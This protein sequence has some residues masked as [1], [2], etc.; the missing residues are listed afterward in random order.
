MNTMDSQTLEDTGILVPQLDKIFRAQSVAIVGASPKPGAR[1]RI[2]KVLIKHGFEGRIYPVSPS[3]DEVEG[4]KA[5]KTLA[6]LPEVPDVAL[7][8]T[9]AATVPGLIE[10]CGEKGVTCA[11]VYSAGFEEI[12]SGKDIARQLKEAA[13]KHNVNVLGPNGQGVWSIKSKTMLTFG[14]AAFGLENL[15]HSPIAIVSQS[16]ALAGAIGN[17]LQRNGLGCSYIVSVGNETCMDA[18]DALSW[19]IEQDDV[20]VVALYLEGL[21]DAA[22]LL[23]LAARARERGVQ[24]VTLKAGRSAFGQEATASHTGKIASP[25]GIYKDVLD[26][27]GIIMVES[28]GE[29]MAAVEVLSFMPDPR[30][31]GDP[32]GG[33][34]VMSSSGGA[35]ALLADHSDERGLPMATFSD[36]AAAKLEDILPEFAR[37]ANPVDLTGQIRSFPNLFRDTLAVLNE[38]P[39]TEAIVVQFASSGLRDLLD[40]GDDFKNAAKESGLPIVIT[41]AQEKID[42]AIKEDFM[43]AGILISDDPANT[44]R[45]LKWLYDRKRFKTIEIAKRDTT[46]SELTPPE[47][48][49]EMMDFLETASVTPANWRVIGPDESAAEACKD[50]TYPLVVKVLP[51]AA[52][53][54][55]ELG[56]VKLKVQTPED[57]DAHAAEFRKILNKPDMGVLVQEMVSDSV[58]VVLSCL[59]NTDF[60][61]VLSIGSGGVA[62]ELYRDV[63]YLALPVTPAQVEAALKKLKL[64]HLLEGFRGAPKAD[65]DALI[66]AA[67]GFGDTI[68][69]TPTLAEAEVNPV[70]VRPEGKG[71]V[72]VDFLG[73]TRD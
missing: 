23:P 57:V 50:L 18:L 59:G 38:D 48:W 52:E 33:I 46:Q 3:A 4:H 45:A 6:D 41:F 29:A 7:I 31:S 21:D 36:A 73:T 28:L 68:L 22:R 67:V 19:V 15:R 55:T 70:M 40:N 64:W 14:A 66:K 37:K 16:G 49:G 25:Y 56:L 34:S 51:D 71:L 26:Q 63:T 35:G 17:Y 58:E 13:R 8:I 32:M 39:R 44:M 5:Y 27:A 1:N 30:V 61:P 53:H 47:T 10:E 54:K 69:R 20:R 62:I 43:A 9:P 72:A 42:L 2:V 24:I 12:E 11:I 65:I 60:G